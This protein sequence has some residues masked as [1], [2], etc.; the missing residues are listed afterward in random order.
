M[1]IGR[2]GSMELTAGTHQMLRVL[3]PT[4]VLVRMAHLQVLLSLRDNEEPVLVDLNAGDVGAADMGAETILP[5]G[6]AHRMLGSQRL[7]V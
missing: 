6:Q 5:T 1:E 3:Y 4:P 2:R 7:M